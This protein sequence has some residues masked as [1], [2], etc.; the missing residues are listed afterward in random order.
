M[1]PQAERQVLV[2][3]DA[4][5]LTRSFWDSSDLDFSRILA[6]LEI[7]SCRNWPVGVDLMHF[8]DC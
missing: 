1:N 2:L 5:L 7:F 8:M 6:A 4:A 3:D